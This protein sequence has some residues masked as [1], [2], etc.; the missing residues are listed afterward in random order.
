MTREEAIAQLKMN[1]DLC[2]FNPMT[3][4][5]IQGRRRM[6]LIDA[7][8][9]DAKYIRVDLF[10]NK[11]AE[12]AF[13]S[14]AEKGKIQA[15]VEKEPGED[16]KPVVHAHWIKSNCYNVRG[17]IY[18]CSNCNTVMFS[19][20][21]YCPNCGAKMDEEERFKTRWEESQKD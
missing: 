19:A 7:G 16:V 3:G 9:R 13:Y 2:N 18:E 21:N 11:V 4:E 5:N 8:M 20:W 15:A 12:S 14:A 10:W 1:R 6:R 17:L